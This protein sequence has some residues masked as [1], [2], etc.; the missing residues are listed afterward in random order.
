M[1]N[2]RI[3]TD[4]TVDLP[5]EELQKYQIEIV[6]LSVTIEGKSYLDRIDLSAKEYVQKLKQADELPKTS[7]PPVGAFVERYEKLAT[8]GYDIISIHMTSGMSG[9]Y[10]SA[11]NASELADANVT[12]VDSKF[13][14]VALSFQVIAAAK[15]AQ[16]GRSKEE[17]LTFLDKVRENTS[18]FIM[19]DTL[20]YLAKG[21][22]LG[23]GQALIGSLLK[24]KPVASLADGVYTPVAKVRT[25]SQVIKFISE[26]YE[27]ATKGKE[28]LRIGIAHVEA[29]PLADKVI[30]ALTDINPCN[31][32]IK[33]DTT[34]VIST[35]T[36]PGAI[37]VMYYT[38]PN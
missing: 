34:P 24:I 25:H 30:Q 8:E 11:R 37:A 9:T 26:Q 6:P 35:H 2:I 4:S 1:K 12:V 22:R 27:E 17:I 15:M 33:V 32:V 10:E 7:Q 29:E 31:D 19:V 36:G 13:I 20:E 16:E 3:V 21:G 14:S 18:L 28:V 5:D 23:R 38:N